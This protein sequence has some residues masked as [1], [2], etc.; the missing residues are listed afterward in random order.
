ME[1]KKVGDSLSYVK[2]H[3]EMFL[4]YGKVQLHELAAK[5]VV[6]VVSLG[7]F[8]VMVDYVNDWWVVSAPE[9]W[10]GMD[11]ELSINELFSKLV[12]NPKAGQNASRNEVVLHAYAENVFVYSDGRDHLIKGSKDVVVVDEIKTKFLDSCFIAFR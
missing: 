6:D 7:V 8:P 12:P 3:P 2:Q 11:N 5:I 1:I 4:S 10:M 9:N